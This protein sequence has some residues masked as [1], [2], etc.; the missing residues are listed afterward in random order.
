LA[1]SNEGSDP[2]KVR[3]K[4]EVPRSNPASPPREIHRHIRGRGLI[5]S[6]A[7]GI[8]DGLVT[9]LAFLAGFSGAGSAIALIRFAGA[10]SMLAGAVSMFFG[11]FLAARAEHDLFSADSRRERDE[12]EHEPEEEKS[13]LLTFYRNKGLTREEAETVVNRVT[14]NKEKWLEDILIHELHLHETVLENPY[15][16]AV[17]TGL[18]FL[19]GAFAPLLSYLVFDQIPIAIEGSFV[20]S[21]AF[22]FL[23]GSWKGRIARRSALRSGL[24]MLAVG[25]IA[26]II[27]YAIGRALVFV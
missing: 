19:A 16:S 1:R 24:E 26:S 18:S 4:Q 15:R 17:V 21:L 22:L 5:S 10:A 11:A 2:A 12:I 25:I 8:S 13:E 7:L 6:L 9:N 20:S 27:L 23:V 14:A 3:E